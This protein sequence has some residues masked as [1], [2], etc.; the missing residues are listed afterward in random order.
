M[1]RVY[2]D[3]SYWIA[4]INPRDALHEA[5]IAQ[6]SSHDDRMIV[7][8][9]VVLVEVLN[10]FAGGGP[11]VRGAACD[12]V[13]RLTKGKSVTIF[14]QTSE[15]FHEALELY[16][17]RR[18]KGWSLTDCA[19]ILLMRSLG[20]QLVLTTDHHFHQAGFKTLLSKSD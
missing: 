13:Q 5:A 6:G 20:L 17:A 12:Y 14:P 11:M 18:D 10:Y 8:S 2:A 3:T 9:E 16:Q 19:S 7:T 4:L 1:T 15:Q